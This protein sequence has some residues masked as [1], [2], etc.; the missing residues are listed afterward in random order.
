MR[1]DY[2][3]YP[4]GGSG[5]RWS[6]WWHSQLSLGRFASPLWWARWL[7]I[8]GLGPHDPANLEWRG[9]AYLDDGTGSPY[10]IFAALLPGFGAFRYPVKLLT[11]FAAPLAALAGAG[12]D[13]LQAGA[14]GAV[15]SDSA[16]PG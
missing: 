4:G 3:A 2:G 13:R 15:A 7:P 11:F 1:A 8:S 9:D 14:D 16:G 12:W 10:A 5:C 6:R